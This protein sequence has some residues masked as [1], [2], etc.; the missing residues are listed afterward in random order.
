MA[1]EHSMLIKIDSSITRHPDKAIGSLGC[2]AAQAGR[3]TRASLSGANECA[4]AMSVAQDSRLERARYPMPRPAA[5][6]LEP[7]PDVGLDH[8]DIRKWLSP[9]HLIPR[10]P[11]L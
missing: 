7:Q 11:P 9:R 2:K 4:P 5:P 1:G 10:H 6:R 3:S 8:P